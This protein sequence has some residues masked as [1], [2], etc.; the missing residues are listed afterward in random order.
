MGAAFW[1]KFATVRSFSTNLSPDILP[2]TN[3]NK[4]THFSGFR[5]HNSPSAP[6]AFNRAA[7]FSARADAECGQHPQLSNYT[8]KTKQENQV[9]L[10]KTVKS[11]R[12]TVKSS[13]K[14][15]FTLAIDNKIRRQLLDSSG[16]NF[17]FSVAETDID[18]NST[19]FRNQR[20][21]D[22]GTGAE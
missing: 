17:F 12:I 5:L 21:V 2:N 20:G 18:A 19:R 7:S 10:P 22:Y 14:I 1:W 6:F 16:M 11:N 4:R 3:L 13:T 15:D 8:G 9:R